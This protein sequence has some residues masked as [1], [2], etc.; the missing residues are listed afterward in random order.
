MLSHISITIV[1]ACEILDFC[2]KH[3]PT[4]SCKEFTWAMANDET[5]D[6]SGSVTRWLESVRA[7]DS[8]AAEPLWGRYFQRL[9]QIM[10]V[11]FPVLRKAGTFEDEEDAALSAFKSVCLGLVD[12]RYPDLSDRDDLWRLLVLVT[13]RKALNQIERS[14]R[15]KNAGG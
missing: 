13:T 5:N 9:V 4:G 10:R 15:K 8:G 14:G 11:R 1:L 6:E 2:K 3:R 12:G 7:G